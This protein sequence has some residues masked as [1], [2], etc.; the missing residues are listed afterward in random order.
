MGGVR[1]GGAVRALFGDR[2]GELVERPAPVDASEAVR[3]GDGLVGAPERRELD[4]GVEVLPARD[5][6]GSV[7]AVELDT[8]LLAVLGDVEA[9]RQPHERPVRELDQRDPEVGCAHRERLARRGDAVGV[10][11]LPV[12]GDATRRAEDGGEVR[13]GVDADVRHRPD[14]VERRRSRMPGLDPAPVDLRVDDAHR[15]DGAGVEQ[16]PGG[17]LGVAQEGDRRARETQS[18]RVGQLDERARLRVAPGHR[19]L[20]VDVLARLERGGR[21]LGMNAVRRQVDDC[22]DRGIGEQAGEGRVV[23]PTEPL[24]E[25]S[26]ERPVDVGRADDLDARVGLRRLA[27]RAGDVAAADDRE[28]K[29]EVRHDPA[30]SPPAAPRSGRAS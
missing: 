18:L 28:P 3:H 17:L 2:R 7:V 15:P 14:G 20:A 24:D 9:R 26:A 6:Q 27:V 4:R 11:D 30:P 21:D 5:E 22:I 8:A 25:G 13:E 23:D 1:A 29:R 12:S 16:A 10:H 19:L